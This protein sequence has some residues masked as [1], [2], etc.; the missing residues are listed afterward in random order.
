MN[1]GLPEIGIVLVVAT[2][3]LVP[4]GV[5]LVALAV[6]IGI[7]QSRWDVVGR[8]RSAWIVGLVVG[9]VLSPI[10]LVLAIV[11]LAVV[12]PELTRPVPS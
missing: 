11:F 5:T 2:L 7:P 1:L 10:G 6:A 8:N 3:A 4:L 9:I 12:R